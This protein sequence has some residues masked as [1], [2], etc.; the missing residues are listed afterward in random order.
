MNTFEDAGVKI[1]EFEE[2]VH[3]ALKADLNGAEPS[4][5]ARE[6]LLRAALDRAQ[7]RRDGR[8]VA[9][10]AQDDIVAYLIDLYLLRPSMAI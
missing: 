3:S 10:S 5:R 7:P 8:R 9:H 2:C 6:A 4:L 1:D